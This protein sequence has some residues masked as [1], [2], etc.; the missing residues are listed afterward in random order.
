MPLQQHRSL[1]A[2]STCLAASLS[3][4]NAQAI[5]YALV[6][7]CVR[8]ADTVVGSG[9]IKWGTLMNEGLILALYAV[10]LSA[11]L[12]LHIAIFLCT[13]LHPVCGAPISAA[14]PWD[15]D[16]LYTALRPEAEHAGHAHMLHA[17]R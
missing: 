7:E 4:S 15:A 17:G 11:L 16:F 13:A 2:A 5:A 3:G 12:C 6:G 9:G 10:C 14:L 8:L 1:A